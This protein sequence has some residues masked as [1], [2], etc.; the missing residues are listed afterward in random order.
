ME[1]RVKAQPKSRRPGIGGPSPDGAAL[2]VAVTEAPEDGRANRAICAAVAEAVG[3]A[4]SAVTLTQGASGRLKTLRIAGDPA[5]LSETLN[6]LL[7]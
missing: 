3:V 4:P 7:A 1:L 2:R 5:R 6:R